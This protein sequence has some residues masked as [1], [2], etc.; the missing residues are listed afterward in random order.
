[1]CDG[2]GCVVG[3]VVYFVVDVW[4][5]GGVVGYWCVFDLGDG[6]GCLGCGVDLF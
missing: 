1:M 3:V 2:G 6:V 4:W 5:F